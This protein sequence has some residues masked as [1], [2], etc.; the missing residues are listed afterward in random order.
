[1]FDFLH[2]SALDGDGSVVMVGL[3]YGNWTGTNLGDADLIAVKLDISDDITETWRWQVRNEL[4]KNDVMNGIQR[5]VIERSQPS[6]MVS[7]R[8]MKILASK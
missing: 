3:S 7:H 6:N 5:T 8:S 2:G 4:V 1:M